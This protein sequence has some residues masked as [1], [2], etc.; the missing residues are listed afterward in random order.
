[1]GPPLRRSRVGE[2]VAAVLDEARGAVG[3]VCQNPEC[4]E[5]ANLQWHHYSPHG[6]AKLKPSC[7]GRLPGRPSIV[8]RTL[9]RT[10]GSVVPWV[11]CTRIP[12]SY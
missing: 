4:S 9:R 3:R 11:N 5:E 12:V 6:R 7:I 10:L 2:T 1:M 8:L